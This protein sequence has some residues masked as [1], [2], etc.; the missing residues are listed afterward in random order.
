M[1]DTCPT[2]GEV[3]KVL[4]KAGGGEGKLY[5]PLCGIVSVSLGDKTRDV[6]P[7]LEAVVKTR[8]S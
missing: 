2:E 4:R 5:R 6:H 7:E 1:R 8:K 3:P